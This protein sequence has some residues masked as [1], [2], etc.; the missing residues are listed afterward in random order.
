VRDHLIA[1]LGAEGEEKLRALEESERENK[2]SEEEEK[3]L[4]KLRTIDEEIVVVGS[5]ATSD[6]HEEGGYDPEKLRA[7]RLKRQAEAEE[8]ENNRNKKGGKDPSDTVKIMS[9]RFPKEENKDK[10]GG[11]GVELSAVPFSSSWEDICDALASKF[12]RIV[13]FR[14][15]TDKK[16]WRDVRS[17]E[18]W[19]RCRLNLVSPLGFRVH[20]LLL[21]PRD[22][23][24]LL[25][26]AHSFPRRLRADSSRR[27]AQSGWRKGRRR[28]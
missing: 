23:V 8:Q 24:T 27:W 18:A 1:G 11:G 28:A 25:A 21:L 15:Q 2:I 22:L 4:D 10:K 9:L 17:P 16:L 26:Q 3:E 6:V 7:E 14:Y 20:L 12:K 13:H 5:V 19:A